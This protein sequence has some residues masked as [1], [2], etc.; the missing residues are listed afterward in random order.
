VRRHVSAQR[1]AMASVQRACLQSVS[2]ARPLAPFSTRTYD[3]D[4]AARHAAQR[5]E[6]AGAARVR[7]GPDMLSQSESLRR[8]LTAGAHGARAGS[9]QLIRA[10][11]AVEA[12]A[13]LLC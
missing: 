6:R 7:G 10:G 2:T 1:S 9:A 4:A 12:R 11:S 8:C 5:C 13:V 3:S